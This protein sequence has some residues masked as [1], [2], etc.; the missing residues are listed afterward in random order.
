MEKD[1]IRAEEQ[2]QTRQ[3]GHRL[4]GLREALDISASEAAEVC[5]ITEEHYLDIEN[6][7]RDPS[8]YILMRMSRRY[9][10][11][12]DALLYD[13]EPKMSAYFLTRRGRGIAAERRKDYKYVSLASGFKNRKVD[14][15]IVEI[16]P[17]PDDSRF[18]PSSH[19]GQECNYILEGRMEIMIGGKILT[20]EQ[21]DSIYFDATRPHCMRALGDE[22]LKFLCIVI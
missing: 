3:I 14:P 12:L 22:P 10:V 15:F 20:L 2:E 16:N 7:R 19:D 4:H 5:G 18:T 9:G 6:G 21:G 13:D 11:S 1:N 17:R 8:V